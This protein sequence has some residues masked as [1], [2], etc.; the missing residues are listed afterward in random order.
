MPHRLLVAIVSV[1]PLC[2]LAAACDTSATETVISETDSPSSSATAPTFLMSE[3]DAVG[4]ALHESRYI[5]QGAEI[6]SRSSE[7][8]GWDQALGIVGGPAAVER[9]G[10]TR[11]W[12]VTLVG[13]FMP[14]PGP[15]RYD[16]AQPEVP[17]CSEIRTIIDDATGESLLLI[18]RAADSCE[19]DATA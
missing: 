9:D 7:A 2:L 12:L 16:R 1:L 15:V 3:S 17:I 5:T 13:T 4:A 8:M 10:D 14:P 18:Y 11:V 19:T 6:L